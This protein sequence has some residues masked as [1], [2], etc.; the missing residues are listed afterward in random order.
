[1]Q[2]SAQKFRLLLNAGQKLSRTLLITPNS[3]DQVSESCAS[4]VEDQIRNFPFDEMSTDED[5]L[6]YSIESIFVSYLSDSIMKSIQVRHHD[7]VE[8]YLRRIA[9]IHEKKLTLKH[10]GSQFDFKIDLSECNFDKITARLDSTITAIEKVTIF[11]DFVSSVR[12]LLEILIQKSRSPFDLS[13]PTPV[14]SEDLIAGTVIVLAELKNLNMYYHLKFVQMFGTQ[15]PSADEMAFSLVTIEAAFQVI[16]SFELCPSVEKR[17]KPTSSLDS[18][19]LTSPTM[20]KKSDPKFDRKLRKLN[21]LL[22]DVTDGDGEKSS[23]SIS[24]R[25]N[26][27][28]DDLG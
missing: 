7:T 9:L 18:I 3:L 23:A 14:L 27:N 2:I 22:S 26:Q 10:F 11:K 13:L 25:S 15:L 1:M 24:S 21:K 17:P 16:E 4:F 6:K 28:D 20:P 8:G 5:I 12:K 19:P